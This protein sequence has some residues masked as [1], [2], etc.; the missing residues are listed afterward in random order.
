MGMTAQ[1][2]NLVISIKT[3]KLKKMPTERPNA[4]IAKN[5][6]VSAPEI[7]I[8]APEVPPVAVVPEV[9]RPHIKM[10]K[11]K[12]FLKLKFPNKI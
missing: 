9:R 8:S 6:F 7:K 11:L 10:K 12:N 4:F 5:I 1:T 2:V 3:G